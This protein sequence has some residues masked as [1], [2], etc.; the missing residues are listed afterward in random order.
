MER[1]VCQRVVLVRGRIEMRMARESRLER[2][3]EV[4]TPDARELVVELDGKA[5]RL[6]DGA[7]L[8]ADVHEA[9]IHVG[10]SRSFARTRDRLAA[11]AFR[12][13]VVQYEAAAEPFRLALAQA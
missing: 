3:A 13:M 2:A 1:L 5:A 7:Q 4:G 9:G 8:A 12:S 11:Q 10:V 6:D